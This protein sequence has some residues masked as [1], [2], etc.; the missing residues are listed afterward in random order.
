MH[1]VPVVDKEQRILFVPWLTNR[2]FSEIS[3]LCDEVEI[4]FM[5]DR[6]YRYH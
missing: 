5:P 1:L 2:R 3:T 6:C 4:I